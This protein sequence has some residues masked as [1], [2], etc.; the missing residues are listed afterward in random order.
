MKKHLLITLIFFITAN[1]IFAQ[2]KWTK[3][4]NFPGGATAT[5]I[6][7]SINGKG[8]V[9]MGDD[10]GASFSKKIY[11]Y[12]PV[13]NTWIRKTD[14]PGAGRTDAVAFTIGNKAYVGIGDA[15]GILPMDSDFWEY[16]A[17]VDT[18]S[19]KANF[20]GGPRTTTSG[21]SIGNKG[22]IG[23]GD[24]DNG[25][26]FSDFYE[27][28][29]SNDVW[30]RKADFE[31]GT[32]TDEIGFSIGGKGYFAIGSLGGF[33]N[34]NDLWKFD[35]VLD[36]CSLLPDTCSSWI[37][38]A[39]YG[40]LAR[41]AA[42]GFTIDTI[43]YIGTGTDDNNFFKDFWAWNSTINTW[44]KIADFPGAARR[45]A[46]GF[47]IG[48]KGYVGTGCCTYNDFWEYDPNWTLGI[49]NLSSNEKLVSVNP[50]PATDFLNLIIQ[51]SEQD[52]TIKFLNVTGQIIFQEYINNFGGNF[53]KTIDLKN[54]PQGIYF[55]QIL[56][57]KNVTNNKIIVQ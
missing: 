42:T 31:G 2:G 12:D 7:F 11:E 34:F 20:P 8:Y 1:L 45:E 39:N 3:K 6:A 57:A 4:A 53:N 25:T 37:R 9:G 55:L 38:L 22:Y 56:S 26:L 13:N 18:W 41:H 24:D 35:P 40:G 29:P 27:Y 10:G 14:F 30:T 44:T 48:G 36:T 47:S 32:R 28:D 43:E 46:I 54:Y 21:F 52:F 19:R 50:N 23:M 15:D 51:T 16:D 5:C 49:N 33:P 17:I